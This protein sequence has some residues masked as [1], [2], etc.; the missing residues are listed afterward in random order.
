MLWSG[1]ADCLAL[2]FKKNSVS[3]ITNLMNGL[4]AV[5]VS[6]KAMVATNERRPPLRFPYPP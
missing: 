3:G 6:G 4:S 2:F 5:C 1:L